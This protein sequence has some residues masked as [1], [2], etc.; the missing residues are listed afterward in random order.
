[1]SDKFISTKLAF[2]I[3]GISQLTLIKLANNQKI[4]IMKTPDGHFGYNVNKYM[5]DNKI[6]IKNNNLPNIIVQ[7]QIEQVDQVNLCYVRVSTIAQKNDLIRQKDYMK[8]RF[9][10]Y[11]I[12]K[13]I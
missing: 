3:L 2:Q 8:K 5:R 13:D 10:N 7:K 1:M 11:E 4:E 12:I 6:N 9:L